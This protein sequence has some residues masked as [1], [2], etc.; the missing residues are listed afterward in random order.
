MLQK[1]EI[2][3]KVDIIKN[4]FNDEKNIPKNIDENIIEDVAST[5]KLFGK[6]L[7]SFDNNK[8]KKKDN[9]KDIFSEL[10]E[11]TQKF[12]NKKNKN[13]NKTDN[14]NDIVLKHSHDSM[15]VVLKLLPS[16]ILENIKKSFFSGDGICGADA[17]ITL[18][19]MSLK[20]NEIDFL[21]MLS[22][23]P[24]SNMGKILYEGKTNYTDKVPI[25]KKLFDLFQGNS[26]SLKNSSGNTIF[27]IDWNSA[28]QNFNIS[29][30]NTSA[31]YKISDFLNDYYST[32]Q[33]PELNDVIKKSMLLTLQP[34][35]SAPIQF[36]RSI[37][38]LDRL[39][40]KLFSVCGNKNNP[41]FIKNQNPVS[42][43]NENDENVDEYFDLDD[44]TNVDFD[45]E[46]AIYRNVLKFT[47]CNNFEIPVEETILED[48]IF[49]IEKKSIDEVVQDALN[50]TAYDA[51]EKSNYS[52]S[53]DNLNL[54]ISIKFI[55]N[56]PKGLV[57]SSLS[58]GTF[59]PITFIF[60]MFKNKA[61]VN[62]DVKELMKTLSKVFYKIIK[63]IF[64]KFIQEFWRRMK[65]EL[66][67]FL[68]KF[69]TRILKNKNK[70]FVNILTSIFNTLK[71][72][73]LSSLDNCENL[74]NVIVLT[75]E[76]ALST[77]NGFNIPGFLLSNMN[78]L[79]GLS[80][81][82]IVMDALTR[83]E[84]NGVST[85]DIFTEK[86]NI[87][88][89]VE[90]ITDSMLENIDKYSYTE[91]SNQ[92]MVLATPAGPVPVPP[93]TMKIVGKLF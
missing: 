56:L 78:I 63:D 21:N 28:N 2:I 61:N 84:A 65:P 6:K 17:N 13:I 33:F 68:K 45:N 24:I 9:N 49:D 60:K 35:S 88:N 77:K 72:I 59:L 42:T 36:K 27:D 67:K 92:F 74:F 1:K 8:V 19:K 14:Q 48:F 54:S 20:P 26:F 46:D 73:P 87:V 32:M 38:N 31:S 7:D 40:N 43:F 86:N 52:V 51:H 34:D 53:K 85:N 23:D 22:L 93:G 66:L 71:T 39:T 41:E 12:I 58:A 15:R 82:R 5:E 55:K 89:M 91:S 4:S 90:S 30:L 10:I 75:I 16:I 62:I 37:N 50:K 47:D 64:W 29:N 70:K 11:V 79:P 81:D 3:S 18:D 44:V 83:L 69:V 80:R 57:M 25:N 76:K